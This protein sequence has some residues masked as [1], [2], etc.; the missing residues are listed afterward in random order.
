M[1][2]PDCKNTPK[3]GH[4]RRTGFM[5]NSGV[6]YVLRGVNAIVITTSILASDGCRRGTPPAQDVPV[7]KPTAN[8]AL[9]E[10]ANSQAGQQPELYRSVAGE[11]E[12]NLRVEILDK[13]FPAALDDEGGGFFEDYNE[14]WSRGDNES[15]GIVY[16][17]RLTWTAAAAAVRFPA[18]AGMYLAQSRH[19]LA[20]LADKLWDRE[21]GGFFWAVDISGKPIDA[22]GAGKEAY[23]NAFGIFAAA[24]NYKV[25]HDPAALDLARK[26]FRWYDQHGHDAKNGGY[27]ETAFDGSESAAEALAGGVNPVGVHANEKSMNTSIHLLEAFTALYGVWPDPIVRSRL[28]EMYEI[29]RDKIYAEP[30]YLIQFFSENWLARVADD[31]YG[32]DVETAYLLTEAAAALGIPEDAMTWTEARR[33]VDHAMRFAVNHQYGGLYNSGGIAGGDYAHEREWWVQAEW[34]NALLLMHERYGR[35]TPQYW[36]AFVRQWSWIKQYEIDK[37][38]GGW[39]PRLYND[40]RPVPL[41]KSDAWTDCYHQARAMLNVSE[42]LRRLADAK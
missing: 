14:D 3:E 35:Q 36:D 30:G 2:C 27:L 29:V 5:G 23:G 17:S 25:T 31:S 1:K 6:G 22:G 7:A 42:R 34:L 32:H 19:G 12:S 8:N 38:N 37:I 11:V 10:N 21:R 16:E 26:A 13:W 15:R 9:L 41:P 24:A 28:N 39:Y 40:N 33:L 4:G 18:E 20:F